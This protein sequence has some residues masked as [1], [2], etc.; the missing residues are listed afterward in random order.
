MEETYK[1]LQDLLLL[2]L[3][4]NIVLLLEVSSSPSLL[5]RIVSLTPTSSSEAAAPTC[6]VVGAA[7]PEKLV[8]PRLWGNGSP[9]ALQALKML[10]HFP[11]ERVTKK[12]GRCSLECLLVLHEWQQVFI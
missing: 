8:W 7:P 2:L 9:Q 12:Q 5:V 11:L 6:R 3:S 4:G 10:L 1:Q